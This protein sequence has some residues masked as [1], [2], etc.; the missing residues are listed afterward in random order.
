MSIDEAISFFRIPVE[1][2][3]AEENSFYSNIINPFD[4]DGPWPLII[5][6]GNK[7]FPGIMTLQISSIFPEALEYPDFNPLAD[8]GGFIVLERESLN[9]LIGL[10]S[11]AE[12]QLAYKEQGSRKV[13]KA[14]SKRE[15]YEFR[16]NPDLFSSSKI[17]Y[18]HQ[19]RNPL[20]KQSDF[21]S[22]TLLIFSGGS[23]ETHPAKL[24]FQI[25]NFGKDKLDDDK[26]NP[27][28]DS[29]AKVILDRQGLHELISLLEYFYSGMI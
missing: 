28:N 12:E 1:V 9:G 8:P 24:H 14:L 23:I 10:L 4:S 11:N 5:F 7:G 18:Y 13:F 22:E 3:Q 16:L 17:E 19:S 15:L 6:L 26:F 25:L 21:S 20:A 27:M 2:A 29:L